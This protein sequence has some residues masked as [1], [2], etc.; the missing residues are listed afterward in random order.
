MQAPGASVGERF[1]VDREGV[2]EQEQGDEDRDDDA[3][4][5]PLPSV[6]ETISWAAIA[7]HGTAPTTHP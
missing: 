7:I 2:V 1:N 5:T 4:G 3:R 6:V